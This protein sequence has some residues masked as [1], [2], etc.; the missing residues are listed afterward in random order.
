[1]TSFT[2]DDQ[3]AVNAIR[4]LSMDMIE[5]AGSGHP[6][7]PLDAAPMV[8]T[9]Y[10]NFLRINPNQPDWFGRDRFV[11]SAGHGSSMMYA[12]FHLL[13]Y[14]LSMQDLKDFR[15]LGSKT[16]GHPEITVPGIDAAT[17]PL[18]QG[19]GMAVGMAIAQ[20]HLAEKYN[21]STFNP[22]AGRVYSLVSDGDLM[23]GI[24]HE[25]ASLAGHLKLDNL[26]VL[27]D[28][29]NVTLDGPADLALTDNAQKRFEGYGW[30]YLRVADGNNLKALNNAIGL[31]ASYT[32]APT[33]IEVKTQ[34]GYG[35]PTAGT[36]AV[37]G[38]PLGPVDLKK[39]KEFYGWTAAP[40]EIPATIQATF[41]RIK[42]AKVAEFNQWEKQF[43]HYT[44]ANPE[45]AADLI[46]NMNG[47]ASHPALT[48]P[49][50]QKPE[51]T[52]MSVHH[53]IQQT[54]ADHYNFWGGSADLSSTNKTHIDNDTGFEPGKYGNRN[55]YFGVREFASAAVANG[56]TLFGGSRTFTS[57]FFVFSDYLKNGIRMAAL[58]K[59]PT[60]F[61]FSHDSIALGPDGPTH[62]PVEQ[63]AGLR[64]IPNTIVFRPADARETKAAW[65][66]S[67]E[68]S[69]S[70]VV[71]AMSRQ[72]V[73]ALETAS[74]NSTQVKENVAH[75][76]YIVS[77][78]KQDSYDGI[79]I[80][81]G[82][83]VSLAIQAQKELAKQGYDVS[84]VSM[85]SMEL[86]D[87]QS[88]AYKQTVLPNNIRNRVSIEMATTA[89]WGKYVGIDGVSIGIDHFG[90]S[91]DGNELIA[92]SGFTVDNIV[93]T[94]LKQF[95]K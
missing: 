82:S 35:A 58:Q 79:L 56:I 46:S 36:N 8:Y 34:L 32:N 81:T 41:D 86:F 69:E 84:V 50:N 83:E 6:G 2:T 20:K 15:K 39:T 22:L 60:M 47:T 90:A 37:H 71:F 49:V 76:A 72:P 48:D 66:Y 12:L 61:L 70:P 51:A 65:E 67:L 62:Q 44:A 88:E 77:P 42:Q 9:L 68:Q 18:G 45:L 19:F 10:K 54:V 26:V 43:E 28:S 23:E 25:A 80:A 89:P 4:I 57:T 40:F 78:A 1:M 7:L 52:R 59:I 24:S 31:A 93:E 63:L 14:D 3:Q 33:L 64:A 27:Y 55:L 75:G 73:P 11:L 87:K 29:N 17:G 38:D 16:P 85:P 94:Y 30:N 21:T 92:K 53:L 91:G 13:G 74:E 95:S 5:H